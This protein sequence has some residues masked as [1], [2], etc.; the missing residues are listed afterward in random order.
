MW[1]CVF[2]ALR[3]NVEMYHLVQQHVLEGRFVNVV[4]VADAQRVAARTPAE[5]A[6]P[7]LPRQR[8]EPRARHAHGKNRYGQAA[9]EVLVVEKGEPAVKQAY[10]YTHG[11]ICLPVGSKTADGP[12]RRS[13]VRSPWLRPS[14]VWGCVSS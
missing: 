9:A 1:R 3:N 6:A 2:Q 8:A 4:I 10:V 5:Q 7:V 13:V 12:A 14:A 11:E